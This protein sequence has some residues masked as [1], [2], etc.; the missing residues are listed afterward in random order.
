CKLKQGFRHLFGTTVF[1]YLCNYRMEQAQQLLHS[2]HITIAQVAVQVGYRN[3]EAFSTAFRRKFAV[4]P[5][6]YQLRQ[7]G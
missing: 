5:K 4:G 2:P 1:G 7:R 6:A 3:P